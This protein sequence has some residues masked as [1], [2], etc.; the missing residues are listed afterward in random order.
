MK[1]YIVRSDQ[2][3][4]QFVVFMELVIDVQRQQS[5]ISDEIYTT[6]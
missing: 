6:Q 5:L 1:Y 2:P 3:R 4:Y